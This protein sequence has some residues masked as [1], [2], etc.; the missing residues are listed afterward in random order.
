MIRPQLLRLAALVVLV[1]AGTAPFAS[2]QGVGIKVGPTFDEFSGDVFDFDTRTGIHAGLFIGG[3]RDKVVGLQTEF[4]WLRKNTA[5]EAGQEIR[6]DYLQ[7]PLLLRLNAGSSSANGAAL[8]GVVGPAFDFKIADEVE[9][10]TLDDGFEGT[11]VSLAFGG[12]F[13]VAHILIEGRYEK[14]FRRI[15]KTFSSL[16]EIKKQSFTILFGVRFK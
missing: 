4:N 16:D 11:D 3:S 1:L 12:G 7:V 6:I 9:G 13:E 10:F 5:T 2:A 15:N 8:Y 14:G